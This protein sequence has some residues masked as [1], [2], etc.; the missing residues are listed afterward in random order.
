MNNI[1]DRTNF[2]YVLSY[3]QWERGRERWDR[4]K[5]KDGDI[6]TGIHTRIL[7]VH[8]SAHRVRPCWI[9]IHTFMC[10]ALVF[11][12]T[13]C[14]FCS[15]QYVR[16]LSRCCYIV[17]WFAFNVFIPLTYNIFQIVLSGINLSFKRPFFENIWTHIVNEAE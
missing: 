1:R 3:I 12:Q 2:K 14:W 13:S 11:D 5:E 16:L 15:I 17:H 8:V 10:S 9:L 6:H 7:L 4:E